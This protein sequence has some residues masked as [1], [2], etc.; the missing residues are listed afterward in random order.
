MGQVYRSATDVAVTAYEPKRCETLR[1]V[2][3]LRGARGISVW[4]WWEVE[5]ATIRRKR[6]LSRRLC[7]VQ[8]VSTDGALTD[9]APTNDLFLEKGSIIQKEKICSW[10]L[11]GVSGGLC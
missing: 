4:I 11:A 6:E 2:L 1:A 10:V 8:K 9:V 5:I 3:P 7:E